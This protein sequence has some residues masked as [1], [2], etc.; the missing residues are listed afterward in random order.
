MT[1]DEKKELLLA[2]KI[3]LMNHIHLSASFWAVL[4]Q[5]RVLKDYEADDI[6]VN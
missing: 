4:V 5:Q 2:K 3:D 1:W 6:K